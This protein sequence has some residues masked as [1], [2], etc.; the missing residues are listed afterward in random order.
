MSVRWGPRTNRPCVLEFKMLVRVGVTLWLRWVS[1]IIS[2]KPEQTDQTEVS[3]LV[4][5]EKKFTSQA[6]L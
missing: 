5:P 2:G 6:R 4:R 3:L 1:N